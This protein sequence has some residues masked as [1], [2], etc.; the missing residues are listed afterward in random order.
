MVDS[1]LHISLAH[2]SDYA[3][4]A[5]SEQYPIGID[6]QWP[7][8]KLLHVKRKFLN[9]NESQQSGSDLEKLCIYW[10]AK[11]ALYKMQGGRGLSLKDD[12][13]IEEFVK[14]KRGTVRGTV[15]KQL[16]AV[17]YRFYS[18]YVLAWTE[19]RGLCEEYSLL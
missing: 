6:I 7:C 3:L 11:E 4:V 15:R 17:H 8:Q 19:A 10:C 13:C 16:F 2:S 9:D 14:K 5:F 1:P 12:I 18:G